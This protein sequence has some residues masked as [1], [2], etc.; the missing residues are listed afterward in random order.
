MGSSYERET[1][2]LF[3]YNRETDRF[4]AKRELGDEQDAAPEFN[5]AILFVDN[6]PGE[7]IIFDNNQPGKVDFIS[8]SADN[9][10]MKK[11][12]GLAVLNKMYGAISQSIR[13]MTERQDKAGYQWK[14]TFPSST[15]QHMAC[16]GLHTLAIGASNEVAELGRVIHEEVTRKPSPENEEA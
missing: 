11:I 15:K 10:M 5:E 16:L 6:D 13:S 12:L 7:F 4:T 9:L 3:R 8:H 2:Y 1:T 14:A